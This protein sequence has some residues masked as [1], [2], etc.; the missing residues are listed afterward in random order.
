MENR[1]GG[2]ISWRYMLSVVEDP[3]SE[4]IQADWRSVEG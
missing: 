3:S 1:V 4:S 2:R